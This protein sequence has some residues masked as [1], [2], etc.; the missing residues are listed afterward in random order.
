[1]AHVN[2]RMETEQI[3]EAIQALSQYLV[4]AGL[5]ACPLPRLDG[6]LDFDSYASRTYRVHITCNATIT[7]ERNNKKQQVTPDY[8]LSLWTY[9][10]TTDSGH[11]TPENLVDTLTVL[12]KQELS[13]LL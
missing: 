9:Q 3:N 2:I 6:S 8:L 5:N 1:M 10:T 13:L 7:V 11:Y 12:R 4:C